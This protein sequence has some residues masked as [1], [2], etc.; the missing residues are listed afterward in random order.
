[1]IIWLIKFL[2]ES[3]RDHAINYLIAGSGNLG[4]RMVSPSNS[5]LIPL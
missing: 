4:I 2:R 5:P 1:M 3:N